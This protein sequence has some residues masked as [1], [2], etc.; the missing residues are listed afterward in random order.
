MVLTP[1]VGEELAFGPERV[2]GA[3]VSGRVDRLAERLRLTHLLQANPFTLSGGE[4]RRL[5]VATM[6]ATA[7]RVLILD[8]PTFGQ[9][10]LTWAELV[11]LLRELID[12]GVAVVS[13]T[14][15]AEFVAALGGATLHIA[16]GTGTL[17]AR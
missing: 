3:D 14:H 10:A 7:P 13:V 4:K 16:A 15:D 8:E 5:S 11:T 9:D 17:V 6:L 1:T 2:G 12:D